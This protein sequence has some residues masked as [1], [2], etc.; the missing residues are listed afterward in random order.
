MEEEERKRA[1]RV[2]KYVLVAVIAI[3]V[4]SVPTYVYLTYLQPKPST[5]APF[6]RYEETRTV[7]ATESSITFSFTYQKV[8]SP[9]KRAVI[10]LNVTSCTSDGTLE[11]R[12]LAYRLEVHKTDTFPKVGEVSFTEKQLYDP[13]VLNVKEGASSLGV[14]NWGF[15]GTF[16]F[17]IYIESESA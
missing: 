6:F 2:I 5:G 13:N 12:P 3:A 10:V 15:E 8:A 11:I 17:I 16:Q 7:K 14:I 1:L 9:F 4:I